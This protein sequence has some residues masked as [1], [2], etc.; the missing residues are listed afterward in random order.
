M[1]THTHSRAHSHAH[2]HALCSHQDMV[3]HTLTH[4]QSRTLIHTH[5]HSHAHSQARS[6]THVISPSDRAR[7]L[8]PFRT[9]GGFSR[10]AVPAGCLQTCHKGPCGMC[11]PLYGKHVSARL[12]PLGSDMGS[13]LSCCPVLAG[14]HRPHS[15]TGDMLWA[16]PGPHA[17][18]TSFLLLLT[19]FFYL[20]VYLFLRFYLLI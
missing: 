3:T 19:K 14:D 9:A 7:R 1:F 13:P 2:S 10:V 6:H 18:L 15:L 8:Y 17:D 12:C 11:Q 4:S 5:T 16:V 20:F